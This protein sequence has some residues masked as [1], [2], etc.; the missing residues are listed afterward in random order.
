MYFLGRKITWVR[1]LYWSFVFIQ[2]SCYFTMVFYRIF[3]AKTGLCNP[4]SECEQSVALPN[5]VSPSVNSSASSEQE[6]CFHKWCPHIACML[7]KKILAKQEDILWVL[8][9]EE[10]RKWLHSHIYVNPTAQE[11]LSFPWDSVLVEKGWKLPNSLM[12]GSEVVSILFSQPSSKEL[13]LHGPQQRCLRSQILFVPET[14]L[15]EQSSASR[16]SATLLLWLTQP[17]QPHFVLEALISKKL[18]LRGQN[19][20]IFLL[21]SLIK[22]GL[23]NSNDKITKSQASGTERGLCR[24]IPLFAVN[25]TAQARWLLQTLQLLSGCP[26]SSP[27]PWRRSLLGV[28]FH[29]SSHGHFAP[30]QCCLFAC[31]FFFCFSPSFP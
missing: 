2:I 29:R 18:H 14:C 25:N 9:R 5:L 27:T 23:N 10:C 19:V 15:L 26:K 20:G 28:I 1:E 17:H 24:V 3:S 16:G 31:C 6:G 21:E 8:G 12:S 11:L 22:W 30:W 4:K 7:Q 13:A